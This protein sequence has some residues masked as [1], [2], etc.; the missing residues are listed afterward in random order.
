MSEP[1]PE[2]IRYAYRF[3][4]D[5]GVSR[6]FVVRLDHHNLSLLDPNRGPYPAWTALSH[7]KCPTCPLSEATHPQCP[8]AANIV[9]IVEFFRD[10]KSFEEV[11]VRVQSPGREYFR[12]VTLQ[13]GIS[14]LIGIYMVS[15]GCPVMNKLRPMVETHLPFMTVEESSY[16]MMSMYLLAQYFLSRQGRRADW[17]MD[18]FVELLKDVRETNAAFCAR[19][20]SLGIKDASLN[21]MATLNALGEITSL[22]I[23][24]QDLD[25]WER[26]FGAHYGPR[27]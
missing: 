20:R 5:D 18:G 8:V 11:D 23:E 9:D 1:P 10:R 19:L 22:S 21:A 15:T 6:E 4:F 17:E 2:P 7:H 24:T 25:R 27:L 14:S 12:R 13:Q 26:I 3:S 16:R